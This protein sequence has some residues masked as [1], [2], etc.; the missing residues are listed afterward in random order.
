MSS[1]TGPGESFGRPAVDARNMAVE[2]IND[3]GGIN[4]RMLQ[5]VIE[6]SQCSHEVASPA[7]ERLTQ[8]HNVKIVLGPTCGGPM[9]ILGHWRDLVLLSSSIGALNTVNANK[10]FFSTAIDDAQAL[11]AT[12]NVLWDD[13]NETLATMNWDIDFA[14]SQLATVV[15]QYES[16]GGRVVGMREFV[17]RQGEYT[18]LLK[19]VLNQDPDGLYVGSAHSSDLGGIVKQARELGFEGR[20]YG[21]FDGLSLIRVLEIA[22]EAA[23]GLRGLLA[24][25][26]PGDERGR[27]FVAKIQ[28]RYGYVPRFPWHAAGAYDNVYMV[29]VCLGQTGDDQDVD[30]MRE[31]LSGISFSGVLG[32]DYGFK[33]GGYVDGL[34]PVVV[35]VLPEG[36]KTE[37][38]KG[39]VVV[40]SVPE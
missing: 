32:D 10:N 26:A 17:L 27:E 22:G 7:A 19:T 33:E 9:Q 16:R 24:E 15:E 2:E 40:R 38:N 37:E 3:A 13:G 1:I 5:L 39:Y 30:G 21:E 4:G 8:D 28:D 23:V 14:R 20:I 11:I 12:G 18:E 31:C 35:E 25:F 36:E 34:S 29:A 6:D